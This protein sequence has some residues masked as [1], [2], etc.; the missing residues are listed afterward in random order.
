MRCKT[1]RCRNQ[2]AKSRRICLTCKSRIYRQ[3]NPMKACY[4]TLRDNAKRRGKLFDLTFAQFKRF[5]IKFEMLHGRGR[6]SESYSV[7]RIKNHLGYTYNNIQRLTLSE[8]SAKG[9][10]TITYDHQSRT[11]YI[12]ET[13]PDQT[14]LNTHSNY[15]HIPLRLDLYGR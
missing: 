4:Q 5:A 2:A 13:R 9:T 12:K 8:N 6:R 7:D 3:R 14:I 15:G 11:G 10:K 1:N